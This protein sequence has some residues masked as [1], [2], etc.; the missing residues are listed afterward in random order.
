MKTRLH[1]LDTHTEGHPTLLPPQ[2]LVPT[3]TICHA[4]SKTGRRARI[5][6]SHTSQVSH[7]FHPIICITEQGPSLSDRAAH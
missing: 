1:C 3:Q 7:W 4:P 6:L 2:P 5:H